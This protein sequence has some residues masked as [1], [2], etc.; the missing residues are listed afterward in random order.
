MRERVSEC[1]SEI[2]RLSMCVRQR[3]WVC[4]RERESEYGER[5]REWVCVRGGVYLGY[6]VCLYVC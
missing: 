1:V 3:E 2:E 5:K 4:A 6:K